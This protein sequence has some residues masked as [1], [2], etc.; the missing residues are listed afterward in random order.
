MQ[1]VT[2]FDF[3]G[4][5]IHGDSV[6]DMLWQAY[7]QK[8]AS[9]WQVL[10]AA[11]AGALYH[12]GIIPAI[13]SKRSAHAFLRKM[14]AE[15]REAFLRAFAQSLY[16]RARPEALK[17]IAAHKQAGDL[18]I[19]C[20]AS[21]SCYMQ[22]VAPL[23]GA[24]ALLCTHCDEY[25]LPCGENC[26]GEEKVHRVTAFLKEQGM[27]NATLVAGYGDTAGDAP[28]LRKCLTPVL[29]RPKKKLKKLLPTA[30]VADWQD[31]KKS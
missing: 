23:L 11:G 29:V 4:T 14:D 20:S 25:G 12:A 19:L 1:R 17:Q 5:I 15:Q 18:F 2:V 3:D 21:G 8:K 16:E 30:S 22:Y 26:R 31:I 27:E 9:L 24:D 28:I 10:Y 6:V 13:A 7:R